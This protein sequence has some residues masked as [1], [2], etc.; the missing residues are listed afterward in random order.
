MID[1]IPSVFHRG[2]AEVTVTETPAGT[3]HLIAR[4]GGCERVRLIPRAVTHE[5]RATQK[6]FDVD[7]ALRT[8]ALTVIRP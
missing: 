8:R 7:S 6:S 1:F 4:L 3:F 5:Y 2:G